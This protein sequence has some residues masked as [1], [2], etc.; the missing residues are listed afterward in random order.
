M[1]KI[2]Y[3]RILADVQFVDGTHVNRAL[4]KDG[5]CWWYRKY[6]PKDTELEALEREAR[7]GKRGLWVDPQPVPPWD[8]RKR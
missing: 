2:R 1:G 3:G 7:E 6:V 5:W 4:V 8:W